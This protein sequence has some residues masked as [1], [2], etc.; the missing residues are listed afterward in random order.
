MIHKAYKKS[1]IAERYYTK[2]GKLKS[3]NQARKTFESLKTPDI[4]L[5]D[6]ILDEI[7]KE[8][9]EQL[10]KKKTKQ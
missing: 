4:E 9:K 7:H 6:E 10:R 8:A 3:Y 5:I 2:L 1:K